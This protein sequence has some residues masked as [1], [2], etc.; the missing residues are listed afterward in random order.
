MLEVQFLPEGYH[1]AG[2]ESPPDL[3]AVAPYVN[4]EA[5]S[6]AVVRAAVDLVV[7][8][9]ESEVV[10]HREDRCEEQL[11]G[12]VDP[13]QEAGAGVSSGFGNSLLS[14][15]DTK[16]LTRLSSKKPAK[17]MSRSCRSRHCRTSYMRSDAG[18]NR[19]GNCSRSAAR[20]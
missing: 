4:G 18:V 3:A 16:E 9:L 7:S 15:W 17:T 6:A 13:G 11:E 14:S 5:A 20:R 10:S 12:A 1:A 19:S 8:R 2:F